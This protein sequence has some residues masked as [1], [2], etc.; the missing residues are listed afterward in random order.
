MLKAQKESRIVDNSKIVFI[1][2]FGKSYKFL[3]QSKVPKKMIK[4][5]KKK[6]EPLEN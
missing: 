2:K 5:K 6:E 4:K 3:Q 1:P